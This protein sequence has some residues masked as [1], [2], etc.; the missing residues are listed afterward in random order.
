MKMAWLPSIRGET[1]LNVVLVGLVVCVVNGGIMV[2]PVPRG[3]QLL[4]ATA[5]MAAGGV[6]FTS[7]TSVL[8]SGGMD[9]LPIGG[10]DPPRLTRSGA[11]TLCRHPQ[12]AGLL[13]LSLAVCIL[14]RSADRLFFSLLL[15]LVLDKK[16][17]LEEQAMAKAHPEYAS[18]L[19]AVPKFIPNILAFES[20]TAGTADEHAPLL[21]VGH[22]EHANDA[23][24]QAVAGA[25]RRPQRTPPTLRTSQARGLR[26]LGYVG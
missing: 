25:A 16:A 26:A 12:Y 9:F 1:F 14:A 17:D 4:T 3:V 20:A 10:S 13:A 8:P 23:S 2:P 18:Y 19:L 22:D 11:F 7:A 5:L 15:M 24:A 21:A 6:L